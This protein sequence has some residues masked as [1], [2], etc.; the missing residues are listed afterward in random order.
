MRQA[1]RDL[2]QAGILL[3]NDGYEWCCFAAQQSAEKAVKA[4]FQRLGANAWG[5]SV[6]MLLSN[7]PESVRPAADLVDKAKE[8]DKHYIASRYPNS[9]PSGAPFQYYT[10][11]E[12]ERSIQYAEEII[13]FCEDRISG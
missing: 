9:Y 2:Q 12:A 4:L 13:S 5:H 1:K 3:E 11:S 6:N 8:L 10:K 7:L